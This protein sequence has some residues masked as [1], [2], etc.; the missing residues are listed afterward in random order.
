M[1]TH[2]HGTEE[3]GGE[4]SRNAS[5]HHRVISPNKKLTKTK[6]QNVDKSDRQKYEYLLFY[7]YYYIQN[8]LNKMKIF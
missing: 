3:G 8:I 6:K 2:Q 1:R 7:I 4:G 5:G